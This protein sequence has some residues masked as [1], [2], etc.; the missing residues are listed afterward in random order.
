MIELSFCV[1]SSGTFSQISLFKIAD[2]LAKIIASTTFSIFSIVTLLK[3]N[4]HVLRTLDRVYGYFSENF[5]LFGAKSA[6]FQKFEHGKKRRYDVALVVI[7]LN[8]SVNFICLRTLIIK[9]MF[10]ICSC[11]EN[12]SLTT[13]LG[14]TSC[15]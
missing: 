13:F 9:R 10:S 6:V 4:R 8:K 14:M 1:V 11:T 2:P 7:G 15:S 3:V 12:L 5:L